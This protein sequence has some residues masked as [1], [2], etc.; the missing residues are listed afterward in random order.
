MTDRLYGT[1]QNRTEQNRTEQNRT[2]RNADNGFGR[3]IIT[4][5]LFLYDNFIT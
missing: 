5:G 3:R 4:A 2:E 1:E